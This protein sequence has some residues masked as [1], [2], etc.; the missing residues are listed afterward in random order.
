MKNA[1]IFT[2]FVFCFLFVLNSCQQQANKKKKNGKN[3]VLSINVK[4]DPQTLYPQKVRSLA[5]TN[6]MITLMEG[7]FRMDSNAKPQKALVSDYKVSEDGLHYSFKLIK[8]NWSDGEPLTAHDFV[9]AY[10]KALT[11]HFQSS[12]VHYLYCI[13][14]AQDV[15]D[16]KMPLSLLGVKAI[17]DYTL[18][19]E[20]ETP[21]VGFLEKLCLPMFLPIPSKTDRI[22]PNWHLSDE[23]FVCNGP[24]KL[25][26]WNHNNEILV[27]KNNDYWDS[28]HVELQAINMMMLDS[29]VALKMFR[30]NDLQWE[31]SPF[32]SIPADE[33]DN[34]SESDSLKISPLLGT[35]WIRTNV[36][37]SILKSENMRKALSLCIDRGTLVEAVARNQESADGLIPPGLKVHQGD[38]TKFDIQEAQEYFNKGLEELNMTKAKCGELTLTY[39]ASDRQHGIAQALQAM[40]QE[41]LGFDIKLEALEAKVYFDRLSKGDFCMSCG[42]WISDTHNPMEFLELFETKDRYTNNTNWDSQEYK[43]LLLEAKSADSDARAQ[44]LVKAENLLCQQLP[45][46]PLYHFSMMHVQDDAVK[47]VALIDSGRIDF[48][49]AYIKDEEQV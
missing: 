20:L 14:N 36:A 23:A 4:D 49:N 21:Q 16:A 17:D 35:A 29:S 9:Y 22:N 43:K 28:K 1:R 11:P 33:I 42:S 19:I 8:S 37:H 3:Q 31:G 38:T 25:E 5:D 15:R 6:M 13:K 7:L 34:L 10:K 45:I 41:C 24:F 30:N 40:W 32:T 39:A 48:K 26:K 27:V 44:L 46:I 18:Q 12:N 47:N 2:V